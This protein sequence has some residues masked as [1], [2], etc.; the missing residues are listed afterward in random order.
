M[1]AE[2]CSTISGSS[3][4]VG[5]K[6][7]KVILAFPLWKAYAKTATMNT[8]KTPNLGAL[9]QAGAS[10]QLWEVIFKIFK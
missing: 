7:K 9:S 6:A 3:L 4:I 2:K 1:K 8:K 5:K 10:T